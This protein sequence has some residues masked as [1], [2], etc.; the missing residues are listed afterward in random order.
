VKGIGPAYAETLAAA[1]IETVGDL[2]NADVDSL[3]AETDISESR[4]GR[5]IERAQSRL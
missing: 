4:L 1:G 5:W 2:A 3:A